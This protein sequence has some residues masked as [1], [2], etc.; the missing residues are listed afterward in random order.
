MD[1]CFKIV[2][3]KE[4]SRGKVGVRELMT[5]P[6]H[7]V[8]NP[9]KSIP[10]HSICYQLCNFYEDHAILMQKHMTEAAGRLQTTV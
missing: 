1:I 6:A 9:L 7:Q 3:E 8:F 10:L 4:L 2:L 5:L